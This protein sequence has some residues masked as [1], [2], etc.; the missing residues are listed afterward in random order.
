M[1]ANKDFLHQHV[2]FLTTLRPFRNYL[3]RASLEK[4]CHY[5]RREF[6]KHGLEPVEQKFTARGAEYKNII[7]S[8]NREKQRRIIVGAHYDVCG[9]QPGR[10]L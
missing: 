3:N 7:A 2:R 5:L 9:N 1:N 10:T 6:E 8:Y 4:V